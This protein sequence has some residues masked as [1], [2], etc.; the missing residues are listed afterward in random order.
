M[1]AERN[2]ECDCRFLSGV[3]FSSLSH[4]R[5]TTLY[6][7]AARRHTMLFGTVIEFPP[8]FEA[9][10]FSFA[11]FQANAVSI[12]RAPGS[13]RIVPTCQCTIHL[14]CAPSRM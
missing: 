14:V 13:A 7:E 5:V 3:H 4:L 11:Y 2:T 8:V 1:L 12:D 10:G 6:R 9:S